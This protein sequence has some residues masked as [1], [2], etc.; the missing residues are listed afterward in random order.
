MAKNNFKI[1]VKYFTKEIDKLEF[2]GGKSEWVD[3]RS[4]KTIQIKRGDFALIPLGIAMQLPEGY[5]AH[6][7]PRSSTYKHFGILQTNSCGIIDTSYAGDN[8]QWFMPV[9]AMRDTT[10]NLNDRVC[11]FRIVESQPKIEFEEVEFL[12]NQD[13]GGLGSTGIA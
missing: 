6:I 1:K 8:D 4:A 12:G 9:I 11:Q 5:E 3:L 13:R 10:I 2:I 7:V